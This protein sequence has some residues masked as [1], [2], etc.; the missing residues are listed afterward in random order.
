MS[1]EVW[2]QPAKG[3]LWLN[4]IDPMPWAQGAP[5]S[6]T[7]AELWYPAPGHMGLEAKRICWASCESRQEC[8]DYALDNEI[9]EGVWGGATSRER[10]KMQRGRPVSLEPPPVRQRPRKTEPFI[11]CRWCADM[12]QGHSSSRYC[13]NTCREKATAARKRRDAA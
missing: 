12:F 3:S 4:I 7:D 6:Q 1:D 5:C 2:G 10:W 8:L 9:E 13:S 11:K